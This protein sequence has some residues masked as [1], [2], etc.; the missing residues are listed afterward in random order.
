AAAP[1]AGRCRAT[2]WLRSCQAC[3]WV[4]TGTS[5]AVVG[6]GDGWDAV[7]L[8]G[9]AV[10]ELGGVSRAGGGRRGGGRPVRGGGGRGPRPPPADPAPLAPRWCRL[11]PWAWSLLHRV[12]STPILVSVG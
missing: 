7:G 6:S 12:T 9:L 4:C 2:F 1:P 11:L 5:L 8:A 3:P 10:A